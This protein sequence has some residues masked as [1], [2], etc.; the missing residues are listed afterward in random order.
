MIRSVANGKQSE[1]AMNRIFAVA[2]AAMSFV[3]ILP[4]AAALIIASHEGPP[5]DMVRE[6]N[7]FTPSRRAICQ[8]MTD[9]SG[10]YPGM[11]TCLEMRRDR[12]QPP[13]KR[14]VRLD[15]PERNWRSNP[16]EVLWP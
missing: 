10:I 13:W 6:L 4:D 5:S 1:Q 9:K 16:L 3:C 11:L 14:H 8:E 7:S 15:R 2:T 12:Q